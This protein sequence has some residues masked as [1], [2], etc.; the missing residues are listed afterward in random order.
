MLAV[1]V[2]QRRISVGRCVRLQCRAFS[3][4]T[5]RLRK[6]SELETV[7]RSQDPHDRIQFFPDLQFPKEA[8]TYKSRMAWLSGGLVS[9]HSLH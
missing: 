1:T 7:L 9:Y 5:T 6:A 3:V 4:S 2:L 8:N